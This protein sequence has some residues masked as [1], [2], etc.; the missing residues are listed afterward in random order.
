M[1]INIPR[2]D[3]VISL[4]N[5]YLN[6]NFEVIKRADNS[7]YANGNDIRL[8]NLAPIALFSN[9]KLTTNSAKHLEDIS[10]SQIVF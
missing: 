3:S 4:F 1:Y 8:I 7:R 6:L 10:H 5:S 2:E 9:F